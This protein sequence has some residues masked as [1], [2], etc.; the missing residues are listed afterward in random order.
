MPR[1]LTD[2][3]VSIAYEV[4][5]RE[6]ATL[7]FLHGC[8]GSRSYFDQTLEYLDLT[9]IRAI[10]FDLRGFGDSDKPESGYTDERLALD[11]LA[12]ADAAGAESFVTVGFS[13]SG[14]FAQYL[15][16]IAPQR[17]QGQILVAGCPVF[18]VEPLGFTDEVR[19]DWVSRAGSAE[20]MIALV[21]QFA[22]TR[23]VD[24]AVL[25]RFGREAAKAS[26]RALDETFRGCAHESFAERVGS[27][28]TPTLVVA[29]QHDALLGPKVLREGVVEHLQ[30]ARDLV[31][32]PAASAYHN[33]GRNACSSTGKRLPSS[34][35]STA[36]SARSPPTN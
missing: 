29:G 11:A 22:V 15:P 25:E 24:R 30:Q 34:A 28:R 10:T 32:V 19:R 9:T 12:V 2:D 5:G 35:V 33:A 21:E 31:R 18:P 36:S 20:R 27:V 16:L 8:A 6:P 23:R 14:R 3:G 17:V 26:A 7:L 4:R 1:V 13:M